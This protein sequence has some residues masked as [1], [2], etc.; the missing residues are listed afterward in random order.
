M[1]NYALNWRRTSLIITA[2]SIAILIPHQL[3]AKGLEPPAWEREQLLL[4]LGQI[5]GA[6]GGFSWYVLKLV[7]S[8]LTTRNMGI[9]LGAGLAVF[10]AGMEAVEYVMHPGRHNDKA[11]LKI[12][13]TNISYKGT[14]PFAVI[15]AG[16]ITIILSFKTV[17]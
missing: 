1:L 8:N 2:I 10:G 15:F 9:A 12:P 13:G 17:S 4:M 16:I 3:N 14:A 11:S 5:W 6:V 7:Q